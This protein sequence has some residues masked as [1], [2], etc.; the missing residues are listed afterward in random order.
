MF[1]YIWKKGEIF[2]AQCRSDIFGGK[3]EWECR[4][5]GTAKIWNN[6]KKMKERKQAKKYAAYLH[7]PFL[8]LYSDICDVYLGWSGPILA[9][10]AWPDI[11]LR[12]CEIDVKKIIGKRFANKEHGIPYV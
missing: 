3:G 9:L 10:E 8:L 2:E 12:N 4:L 11:I 6:N 7:T 5:N 1:Y